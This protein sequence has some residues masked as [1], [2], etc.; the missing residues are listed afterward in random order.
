[1]TTRVSNGDRN[2]RGC[3]YAVIVSCDRISPLIVTPFWSFSWRSSEV[4]GRV[5][6][7][8]YRLVD[9]CAWVSVVTAF[10]L[11]CNIAVLGL[12]CGRVS[13]VVALCS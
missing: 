2:L 4:S 13:V 11:C 10:Y 12:A 1:M 6:H 8:L 3:T 7:G 9:V 5:D